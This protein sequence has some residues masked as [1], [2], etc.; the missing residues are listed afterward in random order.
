M[1]EIQYTSTRTKL[2][3]NNTETR[4]YLLKPLKKVAKVKTRISS[5]LG[6][7]INHR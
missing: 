1:L 2:K 7:R 6:Q 4:L 3:L 5:L